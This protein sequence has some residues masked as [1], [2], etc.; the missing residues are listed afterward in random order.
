[1]YDKLKWLVLVF[2]PA[3]AVLISSVGKLYEWSE[4]ERI[5]SL[6]NLVAVFIGSVM[7]VSSIHYHQGGGGNHAV[8]TSIIK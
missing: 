4:S 2:L 5:M 1:M 8:H 3:L 6:I 7:Q